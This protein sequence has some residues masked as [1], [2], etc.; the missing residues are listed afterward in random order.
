[1]GS[2][3]LVMA[4]T[5][6]AGAAAGQEG[7]PVETG[8]E[9]AGPEITLDQAIRIAMDEYCQKHGTRPLYRYT[10]AELDEL[11]EQSGVARR[12]LPHRFADPPLRWS[13]RDGYPD[14]RALH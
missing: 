2:V 5:A 13:R 14:H 12:Q 10:D 3:V 11:A 4:L 9:A 1:M 6:G 7:G 8:S